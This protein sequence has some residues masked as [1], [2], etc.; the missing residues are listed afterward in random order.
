[1]E[2]ILYELVCFIKI[3]PDEFLTMGTSLVLSSWK[4]VNNQ[5]G[6]GHQVRMIAGYAR[7]CRSAARNLVHHPVGPRG[8]KRTPY[9]RFA[10]PLLPDRSSID[11]HPAHRKQLCTP[12][13]LQSQSYFRDM[14]SSL[15]CIVFS[16][17]LSAGSVLG[18]RG[19]LT[20]CTKQWFFCSPLQCHLPVNGTYPAPSNVTFPTNGTFP[21]NFT[22]PVN[23]TFPYNS[24][25]L[26]VTDIPTYSGNVSFVPTGNVSFFV[27]NI[28]SIATS[29][30]SSFSWE[31]SAPLADSVSTFVGN[32]S[33]EDGNLT[34]SY[35]GSVWFSFLGNAS[36]FEGNISSLSTGSLAAFR[37]NIFLPDVNGTSLPANASESGDEIVAP[38]IVTVIPLPN[39][40]TFPVNSTA[41]GNFS[42]PINATDFN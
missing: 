22:Y 3:P 40:A 5:R 11:P 10:E 16:A 38:F 8:D 15:F 33:T 12:P 20:K 26:N 9:N 42:T 27:G 25:V 1:M 31:V 14:P 30:I 35:I 13:Q 23:G 21:S 36:V 24:T 7:G 19:E 17:L 34:T 37:G 18:A 28:S 29:N 41:P 6:S 39:N 32:V 2:Q 4:L